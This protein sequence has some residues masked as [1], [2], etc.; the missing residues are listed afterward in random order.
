MLFQGCPQPLGCTVLL[1]GASADQLV[2]VKRVAKFAVLAA[3]HLALE[4]SFLAEELALAT[5]ALATEGR[6]CTR[7]RVVV[8][9]GGAAGKGRGSTG[10]RR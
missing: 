3:Y 1:Y 10:H 9:V 4:G 6:A 5:A 8:V 2:R 7:R